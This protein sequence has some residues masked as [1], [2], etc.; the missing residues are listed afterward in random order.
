MLFTDRVLAMIPP[1]RREVHALNLLRR[2]LAERPAGQA[3]DLRAALSRI[4]NLRAHTAVVLLTDFLCRPAPWEPSVRRLLAAC[5]DK[6]EM[7]ALRFLG[8]PPIQAG[9]R[10]IL[11]AQEPESGRKLCLE[12]GGSGVGTWNS[13]L[14]LH[15]RLTLAALVGSGLRALELAP[16]DDQISRLRRFL[17]QLTRRRTR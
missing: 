16:T 2:A 13:E 7:I 14:A 4:R 3:T 10:T 15:R 1:R 9:S 17:N 5:A 12:T 8:S 6:H 11:Q